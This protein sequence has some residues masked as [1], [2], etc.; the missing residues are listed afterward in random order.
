[1]L[2]Q[3]QLN[4]SRREIPYPGPGRKLYIPEHIWNQ[5]LSSLS[6][7]R[8]Y[9]SEGLVYWGGIIGADESTLVTSLFHVN[10]APQGWRVKP[11]SI[12]VKR[13]LRC[14]RARDEKLV[15][16][17]HSHPGAAFH[18]PGDDTLAISF[19]PGLISIVVPNFAAGVTS[20]Q[21]CAVYEYDEEFSQLSKS[22]A[23]NR[24]VIYQQEIDLAVRPDSSTGDQEG[25]DFWSAL[26]LR[27]RFIGRRK[28]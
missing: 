9:N 28:Q 27:L 13:L 14:L 11:E 20:V 6:R 23:K 5:S 7:Y 15:A 18:S 8:Q 24:I 21:E 19:H 4:R 25:D 2:K 1:M 17:V 10:H 26:K 12:T 16:Q 22:D 3:D